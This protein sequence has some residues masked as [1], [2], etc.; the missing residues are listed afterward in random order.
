MIGDIVWIGKVSDSACHKEIQKI[1]HTSTAHTFIV[2]D[3]YLC[4]IHAILSCFVF[5]TKR[6]HRKCH[7]AIA[8]LR[9]LAGTRNEMNRQQ[10]SNEI[11]IIIMV[12]KVS[13]QYFE[14]LKGAH[15][16]KIFRIYRP[17]NP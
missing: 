4:K 12:I 14:H 9:S 13:K 2:W 17:F 7:D 1:V 10:E 16:E 3:L 5:I 6:L 11:I 15:S 8:D